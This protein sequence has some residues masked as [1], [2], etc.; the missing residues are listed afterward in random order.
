MT[1][2]KLLGLFSLIALITLGAGIVSVVLAQNDQRCMPQGVVCPVHDSLTQEQLDGMN[3]HMQTL[4]DQGACGHQNS[5]GGM[6]GSVM[7]GNWGGR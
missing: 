7:M 6:M 2:R 3:K 5:N 1:D 4:E